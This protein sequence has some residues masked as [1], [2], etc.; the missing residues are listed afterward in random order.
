MALVCAQS[1]SYLCCMRCK[2]GDIF[3]VRVAAPSETCS[4]VAGGFQDDRLIC[5]RMRVRR[6]DRCHHLRIYLMLAAM[7]ELP[8][9][10]YLTHTMDSEQVMYLTCR[11]LAR[12]GR[13]YDSILPF[14]GR[15]TG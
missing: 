12:R 15:F 11:R 3:I 14:R 8:M 13:R 10:Q 6:I 2:T 1:A 5:R 7:P 9:G 4:L